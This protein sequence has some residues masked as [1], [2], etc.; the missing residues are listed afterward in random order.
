MPISTQRQEQLE[1][2]L[3]QI[4][5]YMVKNSATVRDTANQFGISKSTVFK[6]V[7]NRLVD[8]D[9]QLYMEVQKVLEHNKSERHMRGGLATRDKYLKMKMGC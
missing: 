4:A 7:N 2:R 8:Y 5:L 9:F 3:E 1:R 6:E